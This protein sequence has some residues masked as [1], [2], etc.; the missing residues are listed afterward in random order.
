MKAIKY[1]SFGLTAM[2]AF[3]AC[4]DQFLQDKK[5][6]DQVG[7]EVYND[8]DGA[9]GRLNDLYGWCL[10]TTSE[11][12]WKYPSCGLND[13][14]GKSTEE[15]A[16]FSSFVDPQTAM[17]S[18]GSTSVSIPD[19]FMATA[20]NIQEAV[21]GRIRNIND[22]IR[23]VSGS[24]LTEAQKNIMLG[25][26][27]FFRAW[28]YYNLVKWYGGVPIVTDIQEPVEDSFTERSTTHECID[29]ICTDLDRAARLLAKKTMSGGWTGSD[30]GRVTTGTALALK[31]RVLLLWAS[32]LFNRA[33]D[34]SRWQEAYNTMKREKAT[35]D[36]LGYGL[37]S[38]ANN[39]NGSDFA[40]VFSQTM[41]SEAVFTVQYNSVQSGDGQKN[42]QWER[43][44]RPKNTSGNGTLHPSKMLIDL[45][46]MSDGKM[47]D[48]S[49]TNETYK[50]TYSKLEKSNIGYDETFP[51]ANRDPRFYRTF[52][53]PGVRWAYNGNA[54]LQGFGAGYPSYN[55]GADYTLWSYV[56][57]TSADDQGNVESSQQVAADSLLT[58]NST[59]YIRKRSD[60]RDVNA[61]ALYSP[62]TATES[63]GGFT[64][65]KAPY[66]EI[67]YAEV[68]LNLAEAACGAGDMAYAVELL[69]Q[70]R[71]RAGYTAENNY[72]LPTNLVS[73]QAACMSAIIYER[74]VEL[75]YEGKRF[76]DLRRWL[77]FD[78]GSTISSIQ[79]APSSW[80]LTGWGG[81]TCTY[82]GFTPLNG[83]R[84]E[85]SEYRT[86]DKHGVGGTTAASDPLIKAGVERCTPVDLS[87]GELD[88]QIK[89]LRG[90]YNANL[91]YKQKKGDAYDSNK[92]PLHMNYLAKYYFFG[93]TQGAMNNNSMIEQ[94]IGWEDSNNANANGTFDP[95]AE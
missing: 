10:P 1:F 5:N 70:I 91:K 38:T 77:L 9:N 78:G 2:L 79:G 47:P 48:L 53:F 59:W 62:Y 90:W 63:N 73:D 51:M 30:Y 46:P 33:N 21:Y 75:A 74:M 17:S 87:K 8:F 76:H 28:C 16:G 45:F 11:M 39:I 18:D 50:N 89:N 34:T 25:Q 26:A 24:T 12:S 27:Y 83:Q 42:N 44:I 66:I 95:L 40:G 6:Y 23:G 72:G 22:F 29:F 55:N 94:T 93:F 35:I 81:N 7:A 4:S 56:W 54:T 71:A 65:S 61:S 49:G 15:Y 19:Y 84:R 57:Y 3:S 41:S 82:L 20:N 80:T 14:A 32:P 43:F 37:Y 68:L 85:N 60:D 92:V 88:E 31:G 67:R 69:Q 52:A 58:N 86:A 36:A 13:I 64:Y